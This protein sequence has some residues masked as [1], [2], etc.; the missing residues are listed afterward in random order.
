MPSRCQPKGQRFR[1]GKYLAPQTEFE[2]RT[3]WLTA[4]RLKPCALRTGETL[5]IP[6]SVQTLLT[7]ALPPQRQ[8]AF[9]CLWLTTKERAT[10]MDTAVLLPG[11]NSPRVR[12]PRPWWH[13]PKGRVNRRRP[14][15]PAFA[16]VLERERGGHN[17]SAG[18]GA[19][20]N[21]RPRPRGALSGLRQLAPGG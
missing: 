3:F 17:S 7:M 19:G 6:L 5:P 4:R 20:A 8:R 9:M 21:E 18:S 2:L 11:A 13:G 16:A 10:K 12:I 15:H 1:S 14:G